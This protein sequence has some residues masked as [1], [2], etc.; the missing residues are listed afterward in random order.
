M[1]ERVFVYGLL[2]QGE[3]LDHILAGLP[4]TGPFRLDGYALYDLG[5]YPAAVDGPGT[6][7]GD[8]CELPHAAVLAALDEAEGVHGDPPLYR[9]EQVMVDGQPAWIYVYDR[10]VHDAPRIFSGDWLNR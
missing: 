6:L 4:R 7:V 3:R 10:P 8:L 5:R 9:R 2:R 1:K